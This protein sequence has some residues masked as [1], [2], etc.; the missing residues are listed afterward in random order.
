MRGSKKRRVSRFFDYMILMFNVLY[1]R[2]ICFWMCP[3]AASV[4]AVGVELILDVS[5]YFFVFCIRRIC[6]HVAL[7][8]LFHAAAWQSREQ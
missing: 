8:P 3:F 1:I 4:A 5:D 7:W 6:L 2:Q